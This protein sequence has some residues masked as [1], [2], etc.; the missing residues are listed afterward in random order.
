MFDNAVKASK[1]SNRKLKI[2]VSEACQHDRITQHCEDIGTN[3][4]PKKLEQLLGKDKV[5][6][7]HSFG[8]DNQMTDID[9]D[10]VIHCGG[11]YLSPQQM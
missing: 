6:I 10:F 1:N 11:C 5:D 9:A 4:I 2:L 3:Q 8:K 7:V